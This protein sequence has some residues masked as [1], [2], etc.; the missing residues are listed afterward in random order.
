MERVRYVLARCLPEWIYVASPTFSDSRLY[1][2]KFPEKCPCKDIIGIDRDSAALTKPD[3]D[4]FICVERSIIGSMIF[5]RH[6]VRLENANLNIFLFID[7]PL[8]L[9]L[10]LKNLK[11]TNFSLAKPQVNF[12]VKQYQK[13]QEITLRYVRTPESSRIDQGEEKVLLAMDINSENLVLVRLS[14]NMGIPPRSNFRAIIENIEN[15][16]LSLSQN[17]VF[18][19]YVIGSSIKKAVGVELEAGVTGI[20][21]SKNLLYNE[22]RKFFAP[23][24]IN[25]NISVMVFA[26]EKNTIELITERSLNALQMKLEIGTCLTATVTGFIESKNYNYPYAGA[27]LELNQKATGVVFWQ[28]IESRT[29]ERLEVG[30]ELKVTIIGLPSGRHSSYEVTAL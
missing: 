16:I 23:Q 21:R 11:P 20:L 3:M 1:V 13:G 24:A 28:K 18:S 12:S 26:L 5:A 10:A 19:S 17:R 7:Q 6:I 25:T 22:R 2:P 29:L 8:A 4:S 30:E 15:D 9:A 14:N 27:R